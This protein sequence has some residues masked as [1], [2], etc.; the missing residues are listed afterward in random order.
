M[1]THSQKAVS[2]CTPRKVEYECFEY[3][4]GSFVKPIPLEEDD[5]KYPIKEEGICAHP[6]VGRFAASQ[7]EVTPILCH[8]K[9]ESGQAFSS[10]GSLK[11]PA[12]PALLLP[13]TP[14][15]PSGKAPL[16]SINVPTPKSKKITRKKTHEDIRVGTSAS[17]S[18]LPKQKPKKVEGV[19]QSFVRGRKRRRKNS[20]LPAH[21]WK[22]LVP[23][24]LAAVF[25][26][27]P[28]VQGFVA[29]SKDAPTA[30]DQKLT[31]FACMDTR[32]SNVVRIY[33]E[34]NTLL[35]E[36]DFNDT[37]AQ[38][39]DAAPPA[40][41]SCDLCFHHKNITIICL[42][43]TP[44]DVEDGEGADIDKFSGISCSTLNVDDG[45]YRGEQPCVSGRGRIS[46][47]VSVAL[48]AVTVA[49]LI[50]RYCWE[51][52]KLCKAERHI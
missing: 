1:L 24:T 4:K 19:M 37:L 51:K 8:A 2:S 52:R 3:A 25:L 29:P 35:Y 27:A 47:F 9:P 14:T 6:P 40:S 13:N 10:E 30:V 32:C 28:V 38:C 22:L 45:K 41:K 33:G 21:F 50:S 26:H 23:V 31:C 46:L 36:T 44:V 5:L 18:F 42:D 11:L 15:V 48:F 7:S 39:S 34:N 49:A 17:G 20:A 16:R 43:A 12:G